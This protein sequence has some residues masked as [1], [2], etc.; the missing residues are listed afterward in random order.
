MS[1]EKQRDLMIT[2]K[3]IPGD[4]F[5]ARGGPCL[6]IRQSI[7]R[8]GFGI[9]RTVVLSELSDITARNLELTLQDMLDAIHPFVDMKAV[10]ANISSQLDFGDLEVNIKPEKDGTP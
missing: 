6:V 1:P 10:M 8:E 9:E 3:Y 4:T 2:V 5:P 7:R